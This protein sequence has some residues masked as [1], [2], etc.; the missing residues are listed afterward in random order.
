MYQKDDSVFVLCWLYFG[1]VFIVAEKWYMKRQYILVLVFFDF[2][3]DNT[4]DLISSNKI[5][6]QI[7]KV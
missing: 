5:T 3:R 7:K 1:F 2:S 6:S 4:V